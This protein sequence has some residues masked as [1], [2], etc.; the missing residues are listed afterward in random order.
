M[1]LAHGV[2]SRQD[3]PLPFSFT[4]VGAA[5][6]LVV[7]FVA[8]GTLWR[9]P[10]LGGERAGRP[11]PRL[12]R[13]VD[14]PATR[15]ALRVLGVVVAAYVLLAAFLGPDLATN[16]TAGVVY[17]LLWV[18]IVPLSLLLGP[19]WRLV[20]PL[21]GVHAAVAA[22]LR[23]DR[24]H[25]VLDLPAGAGYWP[26][27]AG[28]LAF[29]WMELVAPDRATLPVLR[30]AILLY[31]GLHLLAAVVWG[32]RWFDRGDA[33]EVWSDL[34]GRLAP[35][36]RRA[37]GTL[38]LRNPLDGMATLRPAPGLVAVVAVMLGSTGFDSL[39]ST[40]TWFRAVQSSDVPPVLAGT[41]GLLGVIA[42]VLAALVL[43]TRVAGAVGGGEV[44]P[45]RAPGEFAHTIVP[46][47]VGYVVAH[48]YSLL[49]LEGQR[50]L[51][52]L[53]DPL[54]QGSDWLGLGGRAVDSSLV[55]PSGV[56]ALQVVAVVTGHVLGVVLAHDRAVRLFPRRAVAG[57]LPLLVLMVAYTVGG[58]L[59]L[60]AG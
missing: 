28:L 59:L 44:G 3:L 6:A 51:V 2:G 49:V 24:R 43:C 39:G 5:L 54:V 1:L 16:P 8:L 53:S 60:F 34:V 17:V 32:S 52:Q 19:V 37:D 36:G 14:A 38:V 48:Y 15:A 13:F 42:V 9:E 21:R 7:S 41:L 33:F 10:R 56:A 29:T 46:I 57:Q 25:G 35:L 23:I 47:A 58:L 12:Q 11:L 27:A 4:L 26:A 18:G 22:L 30:T 45:R 20:N 40:P 55:T 50:T 31:A